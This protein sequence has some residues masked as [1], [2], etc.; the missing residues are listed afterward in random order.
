[1][2]LALMSFASLIR[3]AVSSLRA[4]SAWPLNKFQ[5]MRIIAW[6]SSL[7]PGTP[8]LV[9]PEPEFSGS[10]LRDNLTAARGQMYRL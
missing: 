5:R 10:H 4:L 2:A 9:Q 8:V 6:A 3:C 7:R 1:M